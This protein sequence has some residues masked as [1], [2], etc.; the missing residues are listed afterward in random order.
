[1]ERM[2]KFFIIV[3][4][5]CFLAMTSVSIFA[6]LPIN[7]ANNLHDRTATIAQYYHYNFASIELL[8]EQEVG[9]IVLKQVYKNIGLNI[10]ITPLPGKRAQYAANLGNKD[11]EIMRIWTYGDENPNSVRVPTPYYYLETMPFVL[12]GSD[13]K[14]ETREALANYRLTKIRGV[15]HTNNITKGLS[16]IYEMSSTE[17]MFKLLL[18]GKVDVVLTNTIDGNLAL[19]RLGLNNVISMNKP[20]ARLPLYHYIHKRHQNLIPL[21]DKEIKQ[22]KN[23]GKLAQ[24]IF[25]AEQ[26]VI[27]LNQ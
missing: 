7:S 19:K 5:C 15:K 21:I 3:N 25:L 14:I 11:G 27:K 10:S 24:L 9:R 26:D 13:I 23:N 6:Q 16:N 4:F 17:D 18:S 1:M 2:V 8:I 22:L 20:L 12:Q